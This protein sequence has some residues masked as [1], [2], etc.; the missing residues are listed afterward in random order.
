MS[1]IHSPSPWVAELSPDKD[2]AFVRGPQKRTI[3]DVGPPEHK[4]P[5]EAEANARLI[6]AAPE[7]LAA[8]EMAQDSC[9]F[10]MGACGPADS[11]RAQ[12]AYKLIRAAIAKARGTS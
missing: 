12:R 1:A 3:A 10:E 2:G 7:L 9:S 8:C 11:K 5:D 4:F 6:A